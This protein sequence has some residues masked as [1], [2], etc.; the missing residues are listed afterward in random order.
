M[1]SLDNCLCKLI[2]RIE[3]G[4]SI[5]VSLASSNT[6]TLTFI[7][8]NPINGCIQ[9][10]DSNGHIIII[11]CKKVE[12][13]IVSQNRNTDREEIATQLQI[14]WSITK[15]RNSFYITERAG[16]IVQINKKNMNRKKLILTRQVHHEGEGGLLGMVLAPDFHRTRNAY[17]YHTYQENGNTFQ[18]NGNILNRVIQITE[19]RQ[20]WVEKTVLLDKIP[21]SITHNGG[22]IKIGPDRHLYVTTGDAREAEKAQDLQTLH[23]KILRMTLEGKIPSDNPFPNSYIYS[24]GHRNPQGLGFAENGNLYSSEHGPAAHD[25]INQ[26]EKGK[27]YGWPVIIGDETSPNMVSPLYQSGDDTWAPSGLSVHRDAIY[28]AGLRGQ[29]ILKFSISIK[30]IETFFEGEG[31]LRDILIE[32]NNLYVIT[33]NTDGRGSPRPGDDRLLKIRL[34]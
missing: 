13:I 22:R 28:V 15:Q 19:T 11:D 9:G 24:Y 2:S 4:T 32:D 26:I 8:F 30:N 25:E 12:S 21:G 3:K 7:K 17:V 18:E 29:Q 23:G 5:T 31:R 16:T 6:I 14:P 33:N 34:K 10:I 27:N 1:K 20:G